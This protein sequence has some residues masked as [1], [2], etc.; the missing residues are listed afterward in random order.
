MRKF[1]GKTA[2]FLLFHEGFAEPHV[3]AA[4]DLAAHERRV[5]RAPMS[6][7]IQIFGTGPSL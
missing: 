4:F 7:A 3:D 5:Q 2:E 6:C 1:L